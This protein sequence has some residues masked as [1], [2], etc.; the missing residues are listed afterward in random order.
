MLLPAAARRPWHMAA[1]LPQYLTGWAWLLLVTA[2][3]L[4]L[5]GVPSC[6]RPSWTRTADLLLPLALV[7]AVGGA[8]LVRIHPRGLRLRVPADDGPFGTTTTI[9]ARGAAA[10]WLDAVFHGLPL[11]L[12]VAAWAAGGRR[13]RPSA[14]APALVF[15]LLVLYA[16]TVPPAV[17]YDLRTVDVVR[18]WTVAA[19]LLV[20]LSAILTAMGPP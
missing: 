8:Y 5:R 9:D 7:L 13:V 10:R 20:G 1:I 3:V 12:W 18:L 16:V 4:D 19:V 17:V 14:A 6:R 2:A 15:G 11:L